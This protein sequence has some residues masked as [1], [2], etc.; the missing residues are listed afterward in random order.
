MTI[1]NAIQIGLFIVSL[2][3]V[4]I[5][6]LVFRKDMQKNI[7]GAM[8]EKIEELRAMIV[9]ENR[10]GNLE[11]YSNENRIWQKDEFAII[12][13]K[14]DLQNE[15]LEKLSQEFISHIKDHHHDKHY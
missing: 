2:I 10:V 7:R 11:K 13:R 14:L 6:Y 15:K 12:N 8:S 3:G 5:A 1:E 9:L 4:L